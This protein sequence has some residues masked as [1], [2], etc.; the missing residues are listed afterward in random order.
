VPRWRSR[1]LAR[2]CAVESTDALRAFSE[3]KP[4]K[5]G[6]V[7]E[8]V[9]EVKNAH[10]GALPAEGALFKE[11]WITTR[12]NA[13]VRRGGHVVIHGSGLIHQAPSCMRGVRAH[14]VSMPTSLAATD[15]TLT[16][17]MRRGLMDTAEA[18]DNHAGTVPDARPPGVWFI[19]RFLNSAPGSPGRRRARCS[20]S[21]QALRL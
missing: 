12:S 18:V 17:R 2:R 3:T 14:V 6:P 13:R 5:S 15:R 10:A 21:P 1:L 4:K 8:P 20:P 7:V 9:E 11:R 16:P 19:H